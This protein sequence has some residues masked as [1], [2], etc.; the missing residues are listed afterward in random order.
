MS[1][2]LAD[3][4]EMK[5]TMPVPSTMCLVGSTRFSQAYQEANQ[6]E[7]LAGRIVL[8]IGCD[9]KSDAMLRLTTEDKIRLDLLHLH[10]I[11]RADEVLVLNVG[12]YVGEST[13]REI[14][15]ARMLGKTLRWLEPEVGA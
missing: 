2:T 1:L 10:K 11:D 15:Y 12:G 8:T 3:L 14:E 6:R 5:A 7:T 4:L 9:T 13:R